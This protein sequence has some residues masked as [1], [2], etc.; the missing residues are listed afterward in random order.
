M[1]SSGGDDG[2]DGKSKN[3]DNPSATCGYKDVNQF[4]QVK[5]FAVI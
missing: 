4:S 2:F 1:A 3:S 5:S